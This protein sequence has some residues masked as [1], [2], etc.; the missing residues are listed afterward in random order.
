[1]AAAGLPHRAAWSDDDPADGL[2]DEPSGVPWTREQA[3]AWRARH[4]ADPS[5]PW[6]GAQ[7][8]AGLACAGL[9]GVL[10]GRISSVQAAL[11]G[12]CIVALPTL[13]MWVA[14]RRLEGAPAR[15]RL[16]GFF[17]LE[18]L[19]VLAMVL[20][21]ALVAWRLPRA[22]WPVLLL[23]LLVSLKAGWAALLWRQR[24]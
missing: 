3:Q 4:G 12:A 8:V 17:L 23:G 2:S 11:L 16:T 24:R 13:A 22:E 9:A 1:M 20:G 6:V 19:K 10:T 21:L 5:L 7:I 14:L 18:G 15:V